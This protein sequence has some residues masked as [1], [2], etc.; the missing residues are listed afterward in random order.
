[1]YRILFFSLFVWATAC[2]NTPAAPTQLKRLATAY[3][4]C[5]ASIAQLDTEL[6]S[7]PDTSAQYAAHLDKMQSAFEQAQTCL[8]PVRLAVGTATKADVPSIQTLLKEQCPNLAANG[9]LITE[10][11]VQQ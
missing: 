6:K 10:L 5:A 7:I 8:G 1:M 4:E 3:C 2:N 11:L 9:E